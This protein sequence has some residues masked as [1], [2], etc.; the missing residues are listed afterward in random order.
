M[1]T[2]RYVVEEGR[3]SRGECWD[4]VVVGA[5]FAGLACARAAA[6][7]G[8]SVLVLE[9]KTE[10]GARPHT[11]GLLW[12][13]VFDAWAVAAHLLLGLPGR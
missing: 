12:P 9:A 11:T 10:I 4:C 5:G 1:A 8:L 2:L 3:L 6:A 7:R 13:E